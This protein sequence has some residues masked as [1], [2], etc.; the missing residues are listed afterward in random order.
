M[1][2]SARPADTGDASGLATFTNFGGNQRWQ[3]RP[4]RPGSE[5][6]LLD[7]LARHSRGNVRSRGAGHSWSEIANTPAIA[8]DVGRFDHVRPFTRDGETFVE[9]GAGC[10]LQELLD[11][12]HATTD[13]TLPTLGAI[14]RQTVAGAI[15]TGTHGSGKQSLSHFVAA[16]RLARYD[17]AGRPT[18]TA[19]RDGDKLRAARCALGCMGVIVAVELATVPK[20]LVEETIRS[21]ASLD[22]LLAGT[23]DY[24]LTHFILMPHS[25]KFF[26][27]ERRVVEWRKLSFGERLKAWF[28]RGYNFVMVDVL[29][30][31]GLKA[32][33]AFGESAAKLVLR[34]AP[35]S[36]FTGIA[37][38]DD[39]EH[40][41]TLRHHYFRHEEMEIFV[42]RSHLVEA[43]E[44]LRCATAVFAGDAAAVPALI[45]TKLTLHKLHGDLI[46]HTGTYVQHY[47][48][49]FR[50]V[51][52]EDTL[53]S[54][55]SGATEP[56][57]SISVFTYLAPEKRQPYYA[58]CAWLARCMNRLFGARL[59]WGK[60]FPLGVVDIARLYPDLDSFRQ[61]CRAGDPNGVFGNDFTRRALGL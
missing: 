36:F 33:L 20:Y 32:A 2:V 45:E 3:A 14:K 60:H 31:L 49:F 48:F 29:F 34:L 53:V 30:H 55:A 10:R 44:L 47:P 11:R 7:I 18:I 54:M 35:R 27:W 24:A 23:Q 9:V 56:Y 19:C 38:L 42:P 51:L 57:Y 26:A 4:E 16:V 40:V 6:Q 12:L 59:H 58:F 17:G 21:Y 46:R 39:A 1:N 5:E 37:R 22:D 43:V 52:P 50:R 61:I 25:W 15:S 8:L 41:L 28:F 13:R